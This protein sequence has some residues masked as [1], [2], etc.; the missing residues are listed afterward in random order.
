MRIPVTIKLQTSLSR[1]AC[2]SICIIGLFSLSGFFVPIQVQAAETAPLSTDQIVKNGSADEPVSVNYLPLLNY[3][4]PPALPATP[5]LNPIQNADGDNLYEVI[6]SSVPE[7]TTYTLQVAT[8]QDFSDAVV[9]YEGPNIS[10]P[11][12]QGQPP[13]SYFYRVRANNAGGSSD[14]S[15]AQSIN[16]YPLHVGL[17][18]RWD[19]TTQL[20]VGYT[21]SIGTHQT[22]NFDKMMDADKIRSA[23]QFWYDPNPENWE[24]GNGYDYYSISTGEYI[25]TTASESDPSVKWGYSWRLAYGASFTD[26]QTVNIDGQPFTVH[27]PIS[28]QTGIGTINYW[29]FTNQSDIVHLDDGEGMTF[30]IHPGNAKLRY[31]A[32]PYGLEI[33]SDITD[34]VYYYGIDWG[35]TVRSTESLTGM[36]FSPASQQALDITALGSGGGNNGTM[37]LFRFMQ[38]LLQSLFRK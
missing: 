9:A 28:G 23:W 16:I 36:S 30:V 2:I 34:S 14:W 26:S 19:G 29:E 5:A 33:Y 10:L 24:G 15:D 35:Y 13:C 8:K 32:G 4:W 7:A 3:K 25:S 37:T 12:K 6:W 31:D 1:L 27:G 21:E 38:S 18:L 17:N 20:Y 11:Y 22:I